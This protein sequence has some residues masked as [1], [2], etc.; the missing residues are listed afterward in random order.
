MEKKKD[1]A[2]GKEMEDEGEGV[3]GEDRRSKEKPGNKE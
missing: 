2:I 1:N 3:G